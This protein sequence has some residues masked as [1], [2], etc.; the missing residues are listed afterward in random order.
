MQGGRLINDPSA[1]IVI[2][3]PYRGDIICK[4]LTVTTTGS[5]FGQVLADTAKICGRA[6]GSIIAT[7]L[8]LTKSSRVRGKVSYGVLGIAPGASFSGEM[9]QAEELVSGPENSQE[10]PV[11]LVSGACPE[12]ARI[13]ATDHLETPTVKSVIAPAPASASTDGRTILPFEF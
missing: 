2:D 5:V 1:E 3:K 11:S 9:R 12:A 10:F 7:E 8:Y 13:P 6:N 4:K